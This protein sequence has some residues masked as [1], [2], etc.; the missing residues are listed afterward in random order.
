MGSN[1]FQMGNVKTK[2]LR[3]NERRFRYETII[4][5]ANFVKNG[6]IIIFP[7]ETVYGIGAS[8]YNVNACKRIFEV[9]GRPSDNPLIVHV[10]NVKQVRELAFF[11]KDVLK[12]ME[13]FWPGPLTILLKKRRNVPDI[14]TANLKTIAVR[15]PASNV[16]RAIIDESFPLAAPS[17]NIS[18][19]PSCT[20][21]RDLL[22]DFEGK[23]NVIVYTGPCKFGIESTIVD[24]SGDTPLLLRPGALELYKIEKILGKIKFHESVF[25]S[26]EKPIAPGMKYRH[27]APDTEMLVVEGDSKRI[28]SMV[29]RIVK[30]KN[31][32]VLTTTHNR[33][34]CQT[35]HLGLDK[36]KIA[37][38]LFKSLRKAD[39]MGVDLI[40]VEGVDEKGIG[41]AIMNRLR[42]AS[43]FKVIKT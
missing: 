31:V 19:K 24:M 42:K 36:K 10:S 6:E 34:A 20:N 2:I 38:N 33:Y 8:V 13:K 27:Y 5:I 26:V 28:K 4:N 39:R 35:I 37:R 16:T 32:V 9:K 41:L 11:G 29:D 15:M 30:C 17:A 21:L 14:V 3:I 25:R 23:V 12:V 22:E 7:T 43:S 1:S 18:G 40:V